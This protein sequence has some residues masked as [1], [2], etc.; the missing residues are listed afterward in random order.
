MGNELFA[1]EIPQG[2]LQ[3]H[4]LNEEIVL[5]VET[6]RVHRTL[7]I[8]GQPLLDTA[9]GGTAGKVEKQGHVE[10]DGRR[11]DAVATE[12]VDLQLHRITKPSDQIDVVPPLLVVAPRRIVIDADDVAEVSI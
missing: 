10:H 11:E 1:P 9:H 4:E 6:R 5:R 8:E 12:K 3:F 7:E 2:V